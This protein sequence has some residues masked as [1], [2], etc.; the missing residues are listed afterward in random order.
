MDGTTAATIPIRDA[1]GRMRAAD[2]ASGAT[3]K[4]LVTANWVSQSGNSAPNNLMHRVG[5]EDKN[6]SLSIINSAY[7]IK[8]TSNTVLASM[9]LS[10]TNGL[11]IR[12]FNTTN[13]NYMTELRITNDTTKA[14]LIMLTYKEVGGVI[15]LADYHVIYSFTI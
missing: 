5:N 3:D 8:D 9:Y 1:N 10:G 13:T 2:P 11:I 12:R 7:Q 14:E 4:T 15:T 6:G